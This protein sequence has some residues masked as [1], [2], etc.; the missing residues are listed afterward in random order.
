MLFE[1]DDFQ[2]LYL[3]GKLIEQGH[4]IKRDTINDAILAAQVKLT[5]VWIDGDDPLEPVGWL[6]PETIEEL[7]S[8]VK[9]DGVLQ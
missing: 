8:K 2:G 6:F 5:T 4:N 9:I 7:I 1:V 3:D